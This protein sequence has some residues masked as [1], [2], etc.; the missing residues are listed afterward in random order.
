MNLI[1][2]RDFIKSIQ[3]L[4]WELEEVSFIAPFSSKRS[5]LFYQL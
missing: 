1:F 4:H 2:V 5:L 3:V